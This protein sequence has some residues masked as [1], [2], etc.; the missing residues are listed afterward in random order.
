MKE[1]KK[2]IVRCPKCDWRI[3][4]KVTPASGMIEAKYPNCHKVVAFKVEKVK[5]DNDI[6]T[7]KEI[8]AFSEGKLL[9]DIHKQREIGNDHI[10]KFF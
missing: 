9:D 7:Y 2:M 10:R 8:V 1:T 3:F 4:D 5:K 6:Q